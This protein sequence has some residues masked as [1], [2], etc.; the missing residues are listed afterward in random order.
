MILEREIRLARLANRFA[1]LTPRYGNESKSMGVDKRQNRRQKAQ[2]QG[3]VSSIGGKDAATCT[4]HDLSASGALLHLRRGYQFGPSF[5]LINLRGRIAYQCVVM[6]HS[7]NEVGVQ[8]TQSLHLG[9]GLD[10]AL[11]FLSAL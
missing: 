2:L 4:I 1:I 3:V 11:R 10:P 7:G 5:Y 9:V 8:F 6:R